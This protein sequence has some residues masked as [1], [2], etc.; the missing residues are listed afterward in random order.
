MKKDSSDDQD[1]VDV[2]SRRIE[3]IRLWCR[4]Y[5][6]LGRQVDDQITDEQLE[7]FSVSS[8]DEMVRLL[9]RSLSLLQGEARLALSNALGAGLKYAPT[10]QERR[11]LFA[12]AMQIS[13][14]TAIRHEAAGAEAL[15]DLVDSIQNYSHSDDLLEERVADLEVLVVHL[16]SAI[17]ELVNQV[18]LTGEINAHGLGAALGG[19]NIRGVDNALSHYES[20]ELNVTERY[21][22]KSGENEPDR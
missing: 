9:R 22:Q 13:T 16:K 2:R 14:R 4:G 1:A 11:S 20:A 15:V 10:L 19:F 3:V 7:L 17:E 12:N 21:I 6:L 5:G 8:Q 18:L